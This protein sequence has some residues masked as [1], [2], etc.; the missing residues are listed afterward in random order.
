MRLTKSKRNYISMIVLFCLLIPLFSFGCQQK[1][2]ASRSNGDLSAKFPLTVHD[3][4]NRAITLKSKP[5]RIISLAPANTEILFAL[6]LDDEIIGVTTYCDYPK[7]ASSKD[8]IGSF[9]EPNIEKIVGL[10][11]DLVVAT[12]GIQKQI[13]E[14]LEKLKVNVFVCYPKDFDGVKKDI[15]AIGTLTDSKKEAKVVVKQMEKVEKEVV[16]AVAK[17][18][19][20]E[21]PTVFFEIYNEP[22]TTVGKDT[23]H[24][25]LI[26]MAGGKSITAELEETYP[27][28]SQDMLI[29]Q[30]PD[31]YISIKDT[32]YDPG[33]IMT[34]PGYSD[35]A[36][37]QKH[38]VLVINGDYVNRAGPRLA[39][40]LL[41]IAKAIHPELFK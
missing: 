10:E 25:E 6:G 30:N 29:K 32:M 36:A 14:E 26:T 8:K 3:D 40:A 41:E 28:Y 39:K 20:S 31:V 19:D 37:I 23:F 5:K 27:Q 7:Q 24:N 33:D 2:R 1:E 4:A 34:R 15:T 22:L 9:A 13:V 18:K 38:R 21:K 11:P 35:I 12:G 16:D 17:L